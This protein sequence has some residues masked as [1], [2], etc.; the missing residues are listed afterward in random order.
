MWTTTDDDDVRRRPTYPISSPN[1]PSAQMSWI[2]KF[3]HSF[4]VPFSKAGTIRQKANARAWN[5][6]D[7]SNSNIEWRTHLSNYSLNGIS[8]HSA[9][10]ELFTLGI[11]LRICDRNPSFPKGSLG[12]YQFHTGNVSQCECSMSI[13][14]ITNL[15][16]VLWSFQIVYT[17]LVRQT[18]AHRTQVRACDLYIF[19]TERFN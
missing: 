1:E 8:L 5:H 17:Y 4:F 13:M 14:K 11:W 18:R 10:F 2:G 7:H 3:L 12:R 19:A 15:P 16:L 9:G 6:A